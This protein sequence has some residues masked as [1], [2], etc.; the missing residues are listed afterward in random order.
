MAIRPLRLYLETTVFNYYFDVNREG[1]EDV[2]RLFEAIGAGRY[3]GYASTYVTDE[4]EQAPEPKRS[5][6]LALVEKYSI[7]ILDSTPSSE[8]L[9]ELYITEGVIPS[10]HFFDSAHIA[11]AAAYGLDLVIP[12]NFKHI[13]RDKTRHLTAVINREEGYDAIIICTAEEVLNHD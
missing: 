3:E 8:H 6:M 12:Y 11:M 5:E 7:T 13:A 10:S 1:H 9:A 4:L 2:V